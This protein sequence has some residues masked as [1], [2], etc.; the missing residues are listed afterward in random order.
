[1]RGG[2][3]IGWTDAREMV[4][5]GLCSVLASDYYYPAPLLAAFR[6]VTSGTLALEQ[7]WALVSEAPA[8]AVGLGDRGRIAPG[9]R[10][11]LV[12]VDASNHDRPRLVATIAGGRVV[13]LN[14]AER[15][16]RAGSIG[17]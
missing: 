15:L 4:A 11:D 13:Y 16:E 17:E 7:A 6:L 5:R 12:L 3:H 9:Q 14:E 2:S 1:V 8:R 10:G